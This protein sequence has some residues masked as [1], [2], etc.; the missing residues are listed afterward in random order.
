VKSSSAHSQIF[1]RRLAMSW[2]ATCL[3]SSYATKL[4]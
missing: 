4:S 1:V 3:F 2:A